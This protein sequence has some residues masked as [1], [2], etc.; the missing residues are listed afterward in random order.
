M[1]RLTATK[2]D[3]L[4]PDFID[5]IECLDLHHVDYLLVGGYALAVH[6][7]VRATGDID[8]FYRKSKANVESLCIA[9][10]DFGAPANVIDSEVL[11]TPDT[12]TQFGQAP[13]RVDLLNTIDGVTFDKAWS[14][15]VEASIGGLI[16][17]V[18]GK[19]DLRTNKL[20]TGRVR[21]EE[22]ARQLDLST[23]G[24]KSLKRSR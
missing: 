5:F 22:D 6:G 18:I 20:A 21:D 3:A 2:T 12:V 24:G 11:L 1:T 7:V 19:S 4:S 16:V 9:L 10:E 17:R 14:R 15:A 8:F 13:H 23:T